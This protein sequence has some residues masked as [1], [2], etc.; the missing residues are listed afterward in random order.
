VK[1]IVI[2]SSNTVIDEIYGKIELIGKAVSK[3]SEA[4]KMISEMKTA[5]G[6]V[7]DWCESIVEKELNGEKYDVALMM[8]ANIAIGRNYP[9][10]SVLEELHVNNVFSSID[11][12]ATISKETIAESNPDIL[13]YQTLGMGDGVTDPVGYVQSMYTDPIIGNLN[14]AKNGLIFTT[15]EGAKTTAGQANQ[16]FVNAYA[17][18]CMFIYKDY[19]TFDI[20]DAFDSANYAGYMQQFW[21]MI[22]S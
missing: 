10:S 22:N 2:P 12:Y 4:E 13:I 19:L 3:E 8:T 14:A 1:Y 11:R 6:K 15:I 21:E 9:Q 7:G 18:Y 20:P 5:I 17:L 16:D